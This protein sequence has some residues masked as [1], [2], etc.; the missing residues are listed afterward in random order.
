MNYE[1]S[2][3][4]LSDTEPSE[5]ARYTASPHARASIPDIEQQPRVIHV[6]RSPSHSRPAGRD[7]YTTYSTAIRGL[8]VISFADAATIVSIL[9]HYNANGRGRDVWRSR[10]KVNRFLREDAARTSRNEVRI[11][12]DASAR[13]HSRSGFSLHFGTHRR[14]DDDDDDDYFGRRFWSGGPRPGGGGPGRDHLYMA[15][16]AGRPSMSRESPAVQ[17]PEAPIRGH[18]I[19]FMEV[20]GMTVPTGRS[21]MQQ[22]RDAMEQARDHD[23]ERERV[24]HVERE[25]H[26]HRHDYDNSEW[27]RK[28]DRKPRRERKESVTQRLDLRGGEGPIRERR[29]VPSYFFMFD[30][31]K[32]VVT[33]D[34][35][36]INLNWSNHKLLAH[37]R[38]Q[39]R[40]L[41]YGWIFKPY[42]WVLDIGMVYVLVWVFDEHTRRVKLVNK[43]ELVESPDQSGSLSAHDFRYILDNPPP[44]KCFTRTVARFLQGARAASPGPG[45]GRHTAPHAV[46]MFEFANLPRARVL[47]TLALFTI[48]LSAAFGILYGALKGPVADAIS[49][50]SYLATAF[51]LFFAILGAG[52]LLGIDEPHAYTATDDLLEEY[53]VH[54]R[55]RGGLFQGRGGYGWENGRRGDMDAVSV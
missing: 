19:R 25:H 48:P 18:G 2:S 40:A 3:S 33:E 44:G 51:S 27:V 49:L 46:L 50:A 31:G 37:L 28:T 34:A 39:Y 53:I 21:S 11:D 32:P 6:T 15:G 35:R 5:R 45:L 54:R 10:Y 38:S 29:E 8:E 55:I 13:A 23:A 22:A 41:H 20:R 17:V 42:T 24:L 47:V 52:S 26:G 30:R 9:R 7:S 43:A 4:S 36:T 12:T 14:D 1:E 16:A